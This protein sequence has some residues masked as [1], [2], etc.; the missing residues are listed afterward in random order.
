MRT[1]QDVL[2]SRKGK[3]KASDRRDSRIQER[4]LDDGMA[5]PRPSV[6]ERA[7]GEVISRTY[8]RLRPQAM[9]PGKHVCKSCFY[10]YWLCDFEKRYLLEPPKGYV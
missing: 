9:K 10:N 3:Q 8:H 6:Q 2:P 5:R 1:G 7:Y 4:L